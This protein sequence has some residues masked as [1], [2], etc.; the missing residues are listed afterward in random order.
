M[1]GLFCF[2]LQWGKEEDMFLRAHKKCFHLIQLQ[3]TV[4]NSLDASVLL[5]MMYSLAFLKMKCFRIYPEYL[6]LTELWES[7]FI[8]IGT[9]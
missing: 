9:S 1:L 2:K 3:R 5:S 7:D 8:Y 6:M 4:R